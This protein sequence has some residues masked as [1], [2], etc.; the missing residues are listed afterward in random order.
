MLLY[1][2]RRDTSGA[3]YQVLHDALCHSLVNRR[4]LAEDF[5]TISSNGLLTYFVFLRFIYL[6]VSIHSLCERA[7]FGKYR[8]FSKA[9]LILEY[10]YF[11]NKSAQGALIFWR[12]D[13][14]I[15]RGDLF[16]TTILDTL[17]NTHT[18]GAYFLH[19]LLYT[20]I[21]NNFS[22]VVLTVFKVFPPPPPKKKNFF[23]SEGND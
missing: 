2:K 21:T 6:F 5:A 8:G 15:E 23:A 7:S 4:D 16:L 13:G 9:T 22:I 18:K 12:G 20:Y 14:L 10:C 11:S 19:V 17:E 1:W 3:T